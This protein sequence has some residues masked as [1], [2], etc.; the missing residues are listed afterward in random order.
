MVSVKKAPPQMLDSA[1]VLYY[2]IND[3]RVQF[4]GAVCLLV[5]PGDGPLSELPEQP[6]LAIAENDNDGIEYLLMFC[7]DRWEVQGVIPFETVEAAKIKAEAGY[8]GI[9]QCWQ[10]V[11]R[12]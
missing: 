6:C 11:N 9:S 12:S 8:Q 5:G 2:A 1:R 7:N 10:T 3:E 4:T